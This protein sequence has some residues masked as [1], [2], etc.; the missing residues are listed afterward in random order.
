ML[1]QKPRRSKVY[2]AKQKF[3]SKTSQKSPVKIIEVGNLI[4]TKIAFA[5]I[6]DR[7]II[8]TLCASLVIHLISNTHS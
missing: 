1:R 3:R 2:S 7:V 8:S 6:G 4:K 5:L